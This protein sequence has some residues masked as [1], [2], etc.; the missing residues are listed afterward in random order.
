MK[1]SY[2]LYGII[3]DGL[4]VPSVAPQIEMSAGDGKNA[5]I[6]SLLMMNNEKANPDEQIKSILIDYCPNTNSISVWDFYIRRL[7][8]I[9]KYY[10]AK[11]KCD[12]IDRKELRESKIEDYYKRKTPNRLLAQPNGV[13]QEIC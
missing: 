12:K 4:P 9:L 1:S 10:N 13:S 8:Q 5:S 11:L 3:W 6:S 7:L 2:L